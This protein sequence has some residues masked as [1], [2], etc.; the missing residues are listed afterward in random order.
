MQSWAKNTSNCLLC[1]ALS[2]HSWNVW[3]HNDLSNMSENRGLLAERLRNLFID[4]IFEGVDDFSNNISVDSYAW[5]KPMLEAAMEFLW[6]FLKWISS[7]IHQSISRSFPVGRSDTI[8]ENREAFRKCPSLHA[9]RSWTIEWYFSA[10]SGCLESKSKHEISRHFNISISKQRSLSR[11]PNL[12]RIL[13]VRALFCLEKNFP[14]PLSS[15]IPM[16]EFTVFTEDPT[17]VSNSAKLAS[18]LMPLDQYLIKYSLISKLSDERETV[19]ARCYTYN[20]KNRLPDEM[21]NA[22]DWKRMRMYAIYS[23]ISGDWKRNDEIL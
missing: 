14:R 18:H 17:F 23:S 21:Q 15:T 5:K 19:R 9:I 11:I 16:E 6:I 8:M 7:F 12:S 20:S 10:S 2:N 22:K 1:D 4:K 13:I 3:D